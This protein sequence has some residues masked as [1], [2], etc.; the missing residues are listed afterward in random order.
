MPGAKTRGTRGAA[1]LVYRIDEAAELLGVSRYIVQRLIRDGEL[2]AVRLPGSGKR[3]AVLIRAD[4]V[5]AFFD[6]NGLPVD[7]TDG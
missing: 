1:P 5:T 4:S 7:G 6:R 3:G 2:Q